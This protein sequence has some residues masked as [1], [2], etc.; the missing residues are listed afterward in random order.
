M[1]TIIRQLLKRL[2]GRSEENHQRIGRLQTNIKARE[3]FTRLNG[4]L[5]LPGIGM[6][7]EWK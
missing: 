7:Y 5:I 4:Q 3:P 2:T 1:K 6:P